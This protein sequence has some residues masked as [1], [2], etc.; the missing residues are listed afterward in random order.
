FR[1]SGA[2]VD[3]L[4]VVRRNRTASGTHHLTFRQMVGGIP[5][6]GA[7]VK[8]SLDANN[9]VL[10]VGGTFF[11]EFAAPPTA[12]LSA[13]EATRFAAPVRGTAEVQKSN[14]KGKEE[15]SAL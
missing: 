1:L 8:V 4:R 12:A 6:F 2:A 14:R 5:V 15:G 7:E 11:P 9:A 13:A 10:S 3:A